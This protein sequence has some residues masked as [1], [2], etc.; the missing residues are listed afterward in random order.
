MKNNLLRRIAKVFMAASVANTCSA[1]LTTHQSAIFNT[2]SS[3][4][5]S[6]IN[7]PLHTPRTRSLAGSLSGVFSNTFSHLNNHKLA[8]G[9]GLSALIVGTGTVIWALQK[10]AEIAALN[11]QINA[12]TNQTSSQA[13]RINFLTLANSQL[14]NRITTEHNNYT[15]AQQSLQQKQ[16]ETTQLQNDINTLNSKNLNLANDIQT[17]YEQMAEL[18]NQAEQLK[19][20]LKDPREGDII[21]EDITE[22]SEEKSEP[23]KQLKL[24]VNSTFNSFSKKQSTALALPRDCWAEMASFLS[25]ADKLQLRQVCKD[26]NALFYGTSKEIP[27]IRLDSAVMLPPI[28]D[29][30]TASK[31]QA[32]ILSFLRKTRTESVNVTHLASQ[33]PLIKLRGAQIKKL[34]VSDKTITDEQLQQILNSCPNLTHL[35][36]NHCRGL[37]FNNINWEN[38][39]QLKNLNL[40]FAEITDQELQP[41]L[42]N[43]PLLTELN[44]RNCKKLTFNNINWKNQQQLK[45]LDL[46]NSSLDQN[47]S[48]ITDQGLQPIL[49]NCPLTH[50]NLFFCKQLTFN[51]INWGNQQQLKDLVLCD[52]KITDQELQPILDNCPLLTELNLRNCKKL[53]FNNINWKNQQQ[54]KFLYLAKTNIFK[55]ELLNILDNCPQLTNLDLNK[56]TNLPRNIRKLWINRSW[57]KEL[58][59]IVHEE[60]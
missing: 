55:P 39:E 46:S 24:F 5:T 20:K 21:F 48:K 59:R 43:C 25:N 7:L 31:L 4:F 34:E 8:Y 57:I 1:A 13:T 33:L 52:S 32:L 12:L 22:K 54:L 14:N 10:K 44:L 53:T 40:E 45:N 19:E 37:T 3:S 18:N 6:S 9:A 50:L 60:L 47:Y 23:K 56:C 41:I 15:A 30:K 51:N 38:Q 26:F 58:K 2:S 16:L 42:D 17:L 11:H 29:I 27:A 28:L 49:D 35:N 36:L